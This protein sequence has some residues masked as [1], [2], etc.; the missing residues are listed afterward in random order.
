MMYIVICTINP[1]GGFYKDPV[2]LD[3]IVNYTEVD[4]NSHVKGQKFKE[5]FYMFINVPTNQRAHMIIDVKAIKFK[6]KGP[7]EIKDYAWTVYPLFTTLETDDD[8][9]TTEIF[10]RS[11]IYMMPMFQGK[12]RDDIVQQMTQVENAWGYLMEQ[13]KLRVSPISVLPKA[14]VLVR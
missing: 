2:S 11:G 7:T 13:K 5:T 1:P 4:F 12:V 10:V 9:K 14:G 6:R 8:L 3:K